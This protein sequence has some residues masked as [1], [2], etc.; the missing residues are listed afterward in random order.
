MFV[1]V[2]ANG[3]EVHVDIPNKADQLAVQAGMAIGFLAFADD[4]VRH[5]EGLDCATPAGCHEGYLQHDF[6]GGVPGGFG[7][8][9]T[10]Q[11]DDYG[12]NLGVSKEFSIR[13]HVEPG[14]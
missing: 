13:A 6:S 12:V 8:G 14:D 3:D 7:I 9:N 11:F 5:R 10:W 2:V 1:V 4:I